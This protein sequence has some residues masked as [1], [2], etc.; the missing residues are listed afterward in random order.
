MPSGIPWEKKGILFKDPEPFPTKVG[1]GSRSAGFLGGLPPIYS[2]NMACLIVVYLIYFSRF[3][4]GWG[5]VA[6][7]P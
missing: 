7:W 1:K 5:E 2:A 3:F 6:A 4:R